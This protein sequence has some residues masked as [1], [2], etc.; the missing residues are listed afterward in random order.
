MTIPNRIKQGNGVNMFV[1][2]WRAFVLGSVC[3]VLLGIEM[4]LISL[5]TFPLLRMKGLHFR[6]VEII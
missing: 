5:Q 1:R 4:V 6:R 2:L 3:L